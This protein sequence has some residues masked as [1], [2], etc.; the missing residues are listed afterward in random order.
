MPETPVSVDVVVVGSGPGGS[1]AAYALARRGARVLVVERG[2]HLRP[3]PA[4]ADEPSLFY[5]DL[6]DPA[7]AFV[8]GESKFY[9]AALYRLREL[10]F[11][12]FA[13]ECGES[14]AWPIGYRDLEPFYGEGERLYHVHGS[15][16]HD[17]TEPVHAQPYPH[18]PIPHEPWIDVLVRRIR[19]QG[20]PVSYIPKAID[21]GAGGRCVLCT[22]C[23]AHYCQLDAK[24]DAELAALRPA[25]AT[26]NVTLAT[27]TECVRVLTA[28]NGRR[29][30][31]VV[32]RQGGVERTITAGVVIV[33]AGVMATPRLL[34]RSR[35][36][37]HPEGVGN[38]A[39][40]LG[41]YLAGHSL[42][43]L[44]AS[45]GRRLPPM[46]QKTFA[47]NALYQPSEDWPYPL[48]VIQ[49]AGQMPLWLTL[50]PR[51]RPV[52][53]AALERCLLCFIMTEAIPTRESGLRFAA[54]GSV[55]VVEPP[56]GLR[57][58]RRLRRRAIDLFHA[59]GFRF[60]F[61]RPWPAM[62]GH[63]VGT[64]RFGDDPAT[65]VCDPTCQVHGV[66]GLYVVDAS[67]LPSAGALNT[68]LT[69]IALALRTA[70]TIADERRPSTAEAAANGPTPEASGASGP[71][72]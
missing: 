65:S 53:R 4:R 37:A 70:A 14:P 33:A 67:T 24:Y 10:D 26:G 36:A 72:S 17:P 31:G 64:A 42:G 35:T 45:R 20:L 18:P 22:R 63:R 2:H 49:A 46:H 55:R 27:D 25:L 34:H 56:Q 43:W 54:D 61:V 50:P 15:T 69:V 41:R 30:T 52:V 47:V 3:D 16:D 44:L 32:V 59:S 38:A 5:Q 12:A 11:T 13:T 71:R 48:G 9:G 29:A 51:L 39:G 21:Y 57:T 19:A 40:A 6:H 7:D 28:A 1:T 68:T 23:D 62:L 60:V 66:E 8:G 58:F